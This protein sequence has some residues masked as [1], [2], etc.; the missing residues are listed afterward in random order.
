MSIFK[1]AEWHSGL[2]YQQTCENCN[3][4][5]QYNDYKLD[6]RPWYPD[7]FVLCPRCQT[8]MRHHESYAIDGPNRI[9]IIDTTEGP[10]TTPQGVAAFCSKCG[11]KFPSDARFCP[12]CGNKRD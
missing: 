1:R 6:F 12:N 10:V 8:P 9:E 3:A 5:I 2:T 4:T 7:G 11:N